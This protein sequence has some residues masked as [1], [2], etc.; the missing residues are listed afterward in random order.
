[1]PTYEIGHIPGKGGLRVGMVLRAPDKRLARVITIAGSAVY[2]QEGVNQ[3]KH[4][5]QVVETW[6][7]AK[8][9]EE[10]T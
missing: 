10:E 6:A 7:L 5:A 2:L 4:L 1:M 8:Q 9:F 3:V